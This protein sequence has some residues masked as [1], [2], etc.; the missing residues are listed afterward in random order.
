MVVLDPRALGNIYL[1]SSESCWVF[2]TI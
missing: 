1:M 2:S